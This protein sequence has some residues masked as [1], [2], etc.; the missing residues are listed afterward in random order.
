MPSTATHQPARE[1]LFEAARADTTGQSERR[2]KTLFSLVDSAQAL[3]RRLKRELALCEVTELGFVLLAQVIRQ[4]PDA[5]T[6]S[7]AAHKLHLPRPAISTILGRLEVSGLI[8]RERSS[9]DRRSLSIRMT[10]K[11][12][13]VFEGAIAQCLQMVN[14]LMSHVD[15]RE[16]SQLD[17]TCSRLRQHFLENKN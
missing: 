3:E 7:E 15:S 16:L 2:C 11:G 10:E 8:R 5:L 13:R 4:E 17:D 9:D 1:L 12:R 6:P 14:T